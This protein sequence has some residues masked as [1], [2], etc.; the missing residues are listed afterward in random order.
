MEKWRFLNTGFGDGIT[1]MAMDEVFATEI[2]PREKISVFR[3]YRWKPYAISLGYHQNSRQL[4]LDKCRKDGIDVVRRPTGGKAV[5]HAQELTY[6]VIISRESK[7]YA[8]DILTTYN[9]ISMGLLAGLKLF[10]VDA[11][12]VERYDGSGKSSNYK[13]SIPC[14]S[15][16][17]K[18]EIAVNDKKLVG[19][20]QRRYENSILQHGSILIGPFHLKLADY[21]LF[22]N[23]EQANSFRTELGQ[24]TTFISEIL[25]APVDWEALAEAI[26]TGIQN[27]FQIE[28]VKSQ[29]SPR[30]SAEVKKARETYPKIGG[31]H[32]EN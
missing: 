15:H 27:Y 29:L 6:S 12:L 8:E 9:R 22:K 23:K 16:S 30:E 3:I 17:A 31:N 11:K 7:F 10:N 25:A 20:A 19:S 13:H 18:Y 26:K 24:K 28:L 32:H 1:N 2:V 14:F 21:I 5:L 4:R